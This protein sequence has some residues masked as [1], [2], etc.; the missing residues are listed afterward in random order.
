MKP[1]IS[2]RRE[3]HAI[4]SKKEQESPQHD[5][6]WGRRMQR[7]MGKKEPCLASHAVHG[8]VTDKGT[9]KLPPLP[10]HA[11]TKKHWEGEKFNY[12]NAGMTWQLS[13]STDIKEHITTSNYV[14]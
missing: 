7:V 3:T 8:R 9:G 12:R 10:M 14:R 2:T 1:A 4:L 11:W 5:S 6:Q 13:H